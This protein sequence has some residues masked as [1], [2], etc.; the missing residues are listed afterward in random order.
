MNR[1][2]FEKKKNTNVT[3]IKNEGSFAYP[4]TTS[5]IHLSLWGDIFLNPANFDH[6][7]IVANPTI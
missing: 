3:K 5:S 1:V 2:H 6:E 7:P 4:R